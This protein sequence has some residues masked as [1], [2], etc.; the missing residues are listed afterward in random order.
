VKSFKV[1]VKPSSQ[2]SFSPPGLWGRADSAF[3]IPPRTLKLINLKSGV[4]KVK[5]GGFPEATARGHEAQSEIDVLVRKNYA[6][7]GFNPRFAMPIRT[8]LRK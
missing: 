4:L 8:N 1:F 7:L 6:H 5:V 2:K 3:E